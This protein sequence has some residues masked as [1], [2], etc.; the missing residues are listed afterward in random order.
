[1]SK[2]IHDI[3]EIY[4][5]HFESNIGD[6]LLFCLSHIVAF[7]IFIW[8]VAENYTR[9]ASAEILTLPFRAL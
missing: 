7:L 8:L 4:I 9:D 5:Y 6:I 3:F 2:N 1:M